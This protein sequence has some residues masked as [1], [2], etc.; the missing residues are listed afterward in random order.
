[1]SQRRPKSQFRQT[2]S[3]KQTLY[4]SQNRLAKKPTR[5]GVYPSYLALQQHHKSQVQTPVE[6]MNIMYEHNDLQRPCIYS[7]KTEL[8][9]SFTQEYPAENSHL[10]RVGKG[11]L[12]NISRKK[13]THQRGGECIQSLD[14]IPV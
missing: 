9:A 1:M 8:E 4:S 2:T 14:N 10:P 3:S 6:D 5:K 11:S 12:N 7:Q 13:T